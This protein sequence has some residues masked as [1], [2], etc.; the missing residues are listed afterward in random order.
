MEKKFVEVGQLKVGN[1]VL[2]DDV[3]C[4]IIGKE[5]SKPGKHGSAKARITAT[6]VFVNQKKT[7]MKPTSAEAESPIIEK[8]S[9][10][11]IAKIGDKLQLMDLTS[12]QTL[13][14][15]ADE[16]FKDLAAGTEVEY[17]KYGPNIKISRLK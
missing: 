16:E 13:E 9:A 4:K 6:G 14:V 3:P 11:V 7:L 8:S 5:K 10:Q 2:I 17:I 12:Y 1:Y 15:N